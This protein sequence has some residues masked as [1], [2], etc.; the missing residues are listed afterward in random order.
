MNPGAWPR[1]WSTLTHQC[2]EQGFLDVQ[3]V[4]RFVPY[5]RLRTFD[6]L[7]RDLF[8]AVRRQAVQEN[9]LRVGELHEL[10]VHRVAAERVAP[11][12]GLLLLSHRG[13]HVR[14]RSEE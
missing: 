14:V 12:F 3:P 6:H 7:G 11:C 1:G 9:G 8:A 13:P 4:L 2:R 5:A 10:A